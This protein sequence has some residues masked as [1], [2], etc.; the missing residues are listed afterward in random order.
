VV[1]QAAEVAAVGA[2]LEDDRDL[3]PLGGGLPGPADADPDAVLAAVA[4]AVDLGFDEDGLL[5]RVLEREHRLGNAVL[6]VEPRRRSLLL[7]RRRSGDDRHDDNSTT[8]AA[9]ARRG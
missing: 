2:V 9:S 3:D 5:D 8:V 7:S 4:V 1:R 6:H